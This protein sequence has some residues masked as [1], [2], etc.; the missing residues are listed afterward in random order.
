MISR[1][2]KGRHL[3]WWGQLAGW[4]NWLDISN[5]TGWRRWI[6]CI[7]MRPTES[8]KKKESIS[9]SRWSRKWEELQCSQPPCSLSNPKTMSSMGC[10]IWP[11]YPSSP[12]KRSKRA[13]KMRLFKRKLPTLS[14]AVCTT[15]AS[16]WTI[17][18]KRSISSF[19]SWRS[20]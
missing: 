3:C 2:S 13:I 8:S 7:L 1:K 10:A 9:W 20:I 6:S 14:Q 19:C 5:K 16:Q 11:R 4:K 18:C 12:S 17:A 15:R